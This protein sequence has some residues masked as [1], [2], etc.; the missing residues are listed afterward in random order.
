[1]HGT[2]RL[3]DDAG[4]EGELAV[5]ET[6][7][8]RVEVDADVG[9]PAVRARGVSPPA[10]AVGMA[11]VLALVPD[12]LFGSRLQ[13]ALDGCGHEVELLADGAALRAALGDGEAP[14]RKVL[15]VDL[16]ERGA[17]RRGLVESLAGGR[18]AGAARARSASTRTWTHARASAPSGGLRPGGAPLAHG[19]RGS[20][21]PRPARL[22]PVIGRP[23]ECRRERG[24]DTATPRAACV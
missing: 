1:M 18:P 4:I 14:A 9:P 22:R 5:R 7:S 16:T 11:R 19:A 20:G 8:G 6:R 13:G 2:L 12:L 10:G 3:L 17:R 21:A 15:V 23:A 24:L